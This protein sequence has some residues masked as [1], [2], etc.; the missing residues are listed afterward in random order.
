MTK[1]TVLCFGDSLTWG[2]IPEDPPFPSSRFSR[3]VRWTGVLANGLGDDYVVIE[4]GLSG[5]T[6][7]VEDPA[8]PRLN[9]ADHLPTALASHLPLDLVIILLGTNDTKATVARTALEIGAGMSVL[10]GQ[11]LAGAGGIGTTYPAPEVL[12]VA[13]PPL[14]VPPDPWFEMVFAGAQQKSVELAGVYA[15]LAAFHRVPFFDAGSVISTEGIDGIHLSA[16]NNIDLG[17][18]LTVEVHRILGGTE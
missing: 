4:E 8:D 12:V 14:A 11:V 3:D 1:K 7:T 15:A 5:R 13:P 16:Q 17:N 6:T 2:W 18:A 10:V 9:G